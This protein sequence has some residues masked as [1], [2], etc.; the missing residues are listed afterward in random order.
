MAKYKV[1]FGGVIEVEA[2][3]D[4]EAFDAAHAK[5]AY[6]GDCIANKDLGATITGIDPEFHIDEIEEVRSNG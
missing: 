1:Y 5:L 2:P 6:L 3:S 4:D